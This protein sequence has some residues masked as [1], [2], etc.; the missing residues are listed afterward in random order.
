[1]TKG[2]NLGPPGS[3]ASA[4]ALPVF[5]GSKPQN[6]LKFLASKSQKSK[7][8]TIPGL[9]ASKCPKIPGLED[10][11]S[12]N[13]LKFMASKSCCALAVFSPDWRQWI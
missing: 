12:Q 7:N 1:M 4:Y 3:T 10:S 9:E 8:T 11:K 2:A 13:T 6:T 5:L